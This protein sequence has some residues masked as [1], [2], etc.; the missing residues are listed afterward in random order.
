MGRLKKKSIESAKGTEFDV[1]IKKCPT[2]RP[3]LMLLNSRAGSSTPEV[4]Y[5]CAARLL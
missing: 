3:V 1:Q 4:N 2:D 5:V